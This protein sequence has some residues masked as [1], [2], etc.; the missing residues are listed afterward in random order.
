MVWCVCHGEYILTRD[1][2]SSEFLECEQFLLE[3]IS[4]ASW[5]WFGP[6]SN[7]GSA[8]SLDSLYTC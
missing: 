6:I 1:L 7:D 3:A 5:P 4:S 2:T 8:Q